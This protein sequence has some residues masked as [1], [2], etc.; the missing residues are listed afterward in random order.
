M[1][2]SVKEILL[3]EDQEY[4]IHFL[5]LLIKSINPLVNEGQTYEILYQMVVDM[6][7]DAGCALS[8][9]ESYAKLINKTIGKS[10]RKNLNWHGQ[11]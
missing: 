2:P 11:N 8:D 5:T 4:F 9:A 1:A 3:E 10:T 6:E 7:S